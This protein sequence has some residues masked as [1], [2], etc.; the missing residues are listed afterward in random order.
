MFDKQRWKLKI[1]GRIALG[2]IIILLMLGLFLAIVSH[3]ISEL[4]KETVFLSE[5]DVQVHELTY[6]I[7]KNV[8]DMET[9]QRGYALTDNTE[10]L[11]PYNSGIV[12]WRINYAKLKGLI[13]DNPSQIQNL[14]DIKSNIELWVSSAGEYVIDLKRNGQDEAVS[15]Y[16]HNDTGKPLVDLIRSESEYFR[17][18]ER[19]LTNERVISLK[20]G[21]DKLLI[22]MYILWSVVAL[23]ATLIT[24]VISRSIVNPLQRVTLAIHNI[25]SGGNLSERIEVRTIDEI[26]ELGDATNRLL[27]TV[28]REQWSNE[29]LTTM[30]V[31]LQETVDLPFLCRTFL[32]KLSTILEMQYGAIY[33]LNEE[34]QLV[35]VYMYAGNGKN[36]EFPATENIIMGEGLIGQC[37]VDK[38]MMVI[39]DLPED[40]IRIH[41]GLGRTAPRFAIIAPVIFENKIVAVIEIAS[42]TKWASYHLDLLTDLLNML[43]VTLN[44]VTTRME[45]QKLY[46]ESQ[47][48]NEELQVQSEE[49]QVQSEELQSFTQELIVL[50]KDL[51]NQKTEAEIAAIEL[52]EFNEQLQLSSRYK[53][54]FLAN[55][56]HELRTP[57]NSMLILSQ[58]LA[59]NRNETLNQE[60]QGYAAVIYSSGQDL[61]N[62]INDILDLSKAEA[63]KML[64]EYDAVNLTEIPPMLQA[65]FRQTA[66][67]KSLDFSITLGNNVPDLFYTDGMR[68]HQILRN[69]LSNAFKFTETGGV[70]V[71]IA[72]LESYHSP[73]YE[74]EGPV[75]SFSVKDTGIGISEENNEL[76]FEAFRQADGST[77]RKFGGTGLG[78]SISLQ[79]ARLLGGQIQ[80][81]SVPGEG[82]NFTLYLPCREEDPEYDV[83]TSKFR[84]EVAASHDTVDDISRNLINNGG[85]FDKEY[86]LLQGKT[87]LI[88]D[89]DSRNIFAL[90]KGL[91]PYD[92]N[93]LTAQTGFECLQIVREQPDVDIVLLDIMMPNLDGYDTL[94]IIREE[95]LLPEIPIIAISAKT[96]K[97]ER[98]K[99]LSAGATDFISKPVVMHEVVTRMYKWLSHTK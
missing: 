43:G 66:E 42:L 76:I 13:A 61:L 53:S 21:N 54:E 12:E 7:E 97:E 47:V 82:S 19:H 79:L 89:D 49:L 31:L 72:R 26:Y 96:M 75:L 16:F 6:Q 55:M 14:D 81:Q 77:A 48:M 1:R 58:L 70:H 23:I 90:R 34:Q 87:V 68:L 28:Q 40:Y 9:G 99:C 62:M 92:M 57:L 37:A 33:V 24:I 45:I 18:N 50:N 59:E 60:E 44:S 39:E 85:T 27:E 78:L 20:Q 95:L 32:N 15:T 84:S 67:Q 8:L 46:G 98:E 22:T 86:S 63:G 74:S 4:E 36:K 29:Q 38:R 11:T 91:E 83:V 5:H 69:L 65:Y 56:S 94:S 10:Y 2:Y 35:R 88:V 73:Q 30:S 93:I 3:R 71:E 51:N 64:V 52:E 25:A 80:L 41:S 17:E